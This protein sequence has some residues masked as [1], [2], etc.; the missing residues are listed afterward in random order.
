M[1]GLG[2]G[3]SGSASAPVRTAPVTAPAP[4]RRGTPV[5]ERPAPRAARPSRHRRDIQGLRAV[6]VLLVVAY[7]CGLPLVGGGYVGVDVFFVIS[8]FLITGLL[9]RE[10]RETGRISV[11]GFYARRALRLLPAATVVVV[12]TVAMSVW[13][14]PPL[15][16]P[17]I[18]ADALYTTGYAMNY[19]LAVIGTDYLSA[20]T[21]PSPLQHFWSLAVEEQFY[22]V[23]PLLLLLVVVHAQ[24]SAAAGRKPGARGD[25]SRIALLL[26]G[27]T[28]AS[29]AVSVWQTRHNAAWA[30]F[31]AHTRAWELGVGA[32]L[33]L[34][35]G[36]A[37]RLGRRAALALATAGLLA[38]AAAA[39]TYTEATP[40]P[41]YAALLPVLGAAAVIAGGC[42]C[43][44]PPLGHPALQA[45]GRLSYSWYL[46]HW[47]LL[48]VAPY[49]LG[50]PPAWWQSILAALAALVLAALTYALVENPFRRLPVLRRRPWRGLAAGLVMSA[51][52]VALC[53]TLTA[54]NG[55]A[56]SG[57]RA[58]PLAPQSNVTALQ[59]RIADSVHLPAVPVDLTPKLSRAARD[60]PQLYKDLCSPEFTEWLIK[61]CAYG[62]PNSPTTVVLFGDSHAGHWFPALEA[63]A[64]QRHW[65]LV[66]LVKSA[67]SAA[68][69]YIYQDSLKRPFTECVK[70]RRAAYQKIRE[71]RPAMVVL[72]S[73]SPGGALLGVT[74]GLDTTWMRAWQY[75]FTQVSAPGTKVYFVN[76]TPWHNLVPDCL[77][78]HMSDPAACAHP[79]A[80]AVRAPELRAR[81]MDLARGQGV[82][83][84]DPL[85]WFCTATDCPVIIGNVLVYKDRHHIT[86]VYSRLLAPLLS[87][88]LVP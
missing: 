17:D 11:P 30:Y 58:A 3:T 6:A 10:V 80:V 32:L 64:R 20:E 62:D 88:E 35:A 27:L 53:V 40:F 45:I 31:G 26:M 13:W 69:V 79:R 33:A 12:A 82:S 55:T 24:R 52:S 78:Q 66:P 23:W 51:A 63:V 72:A 38:I 60:K 47:P 25:L 84:I 74:G 18:L 28:A 48:A 86:T 57:Y 50:H 87:A 77:S 22:L 2:T 41:G 4:R 75:T 14:L 42:A 68:N 34:G 61:D 39:V 59:Q 56:V 85:P 8:G 19:R 29:F 71:L 65:K 43:P 81:V 46:W 16:L 83:V 70:W 36:A 7:H 49:L 73:V 9:L 15:R 1:T 37:A 54:E 21:D 76:D 5:A 67:C 44:A